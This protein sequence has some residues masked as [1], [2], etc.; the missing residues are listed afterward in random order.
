[1]LAELN[2]R[3]C[4]KFNSRDVGI[5]LCKALLFAKWL[6]S[7]APPRTLNP[8]GPK[9]PNIVFTDGAAEGRDREEVTIGGVLVSAESGKLRFFSSSVPSEIVAGWRES[10]SRQVIGQGEIYPVLVAKM[11]WRSH[12]SQRRNIFFID[13]DSARYAL[14]SGVSPVESSKELLLLFNCILDAMQ[15]ALNWY[16]RVPSKGNVSDGPSRGDSSYVRS[17]RAVEDKA[18]LPTALELGRCSCRQIVGLTR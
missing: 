13:N 14:I 10:G 3:A 2:A 12:L 15:P 9:R 1:V 8:F 4:D 16:S 18:I 5:G 11:T 6:V 7:H 17:L